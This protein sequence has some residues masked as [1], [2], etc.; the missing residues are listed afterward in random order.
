MLRR[1]STKLIVLAALVTGAAAVSVAGGSHESRASGYYPGFGGQSAALDGITVT[2][3]GVTR[4]PRP[5]KLTDRTIAQAVAAAQA[6]AFPA[7]VADAR[8]HADAIAR[9]LGLEIG[10]V[11]AV[12]DTGDAYS[13]G[14]A[15]R[16]GTKRHC[17]AISRRIFRH[18]ET[19]RR[20][21][22]RS[23]RRHK[24]IVPKQSVV[25]LTVR[26]EKG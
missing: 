2:G 8:A 23:K 25:T 13:S 6:A 12:A 24:C 14:V 10:A 3:I 18:D 7:A 9:S 1:R 15:G 26:F 19:G 22:R 21:L 16:F 4:V 17:G 5:A 11:E 20:V